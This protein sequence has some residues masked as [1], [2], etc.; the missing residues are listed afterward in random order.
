MKTQKEQDV[1]EYLKTYY[2]AYFYMTIE[3]LEKEVGSLYS[4]SQSLYDK[5]LATEILAEKVKIYLE[6][7]KE[8]GNEVM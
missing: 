2:P 1:I 5:A 8:Q 7:I 3:E 4:E 6:V